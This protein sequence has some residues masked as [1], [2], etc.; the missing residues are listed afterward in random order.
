MQLW[1]QK[2]VKGTVGTERHGWTTA[3]QGEIDSIKA[4]GVMD[5]ISISEVRRMEAESGKKVDIL[6]TKNMWAEKPWGPGCEKAGRTKR[7]RELSCAA[8][9]KTRSKRKC[10]LP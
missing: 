9:S 7:K 4:M 8:T 2:Q 1:T 5:T 3:L 10:I 6:P